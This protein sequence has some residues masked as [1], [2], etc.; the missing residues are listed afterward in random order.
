[1]QRFE[2]APMRA[3]AMS[4]R[5][6]FRGEIDP[7]RGGRSELIEGMFRPIRRPSLPPSF[8]AVRTDQLAEDLPQVH[9]S[10][11]IVPI[12]ATSPSFAARCSWRAATGWIPP[13]SCGELSQV[14]GPRMSAWRLCRAGRS[15]VLRRRAR[16]TRER[17]RQWSANLD[18]AKA[19][20][21]QVELLLGVARGLLRAAEDASHATE[22]NPDLIK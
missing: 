16:P 14:R 15:G 17:R 22:S 3:M 13:T 2:K 21:G 18:L 19:I 20:L 4:V 6:G 5:G 7:L 1:M 8:G 12:D 11:T 9:G 10:G